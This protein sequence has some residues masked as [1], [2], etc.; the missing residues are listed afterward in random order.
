MREEEDF[1]IRLVQHGQWTWLRFPEKLSAGI[2]FT[3]MQFIRN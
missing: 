1:G 2:V 3:T